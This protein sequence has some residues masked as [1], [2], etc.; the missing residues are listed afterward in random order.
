MRA[1]SEPNSNVVDNEVKDTKSSVT[2]CSS[3][4]VQSGPLL[5]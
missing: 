5:L 3:L 4:Q 2:N 1:V